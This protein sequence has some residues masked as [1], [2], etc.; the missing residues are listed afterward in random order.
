MSENTK[1]DSDRILTKRTFFWKNSLKSEVLLVFFAFVQFLLYL[2]P[3]LC[4]WGS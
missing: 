3:D 4:K 1:G 2:C